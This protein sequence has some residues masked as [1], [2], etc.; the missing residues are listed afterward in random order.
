MFANFQIRTLFLVV[1]FFILFNLGG[2]D[3]TRQTYELV[4]HLLDDAINTDASLEG[5]ERPKEPRYD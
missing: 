3:D 1:F 2:V 4:E 5:A